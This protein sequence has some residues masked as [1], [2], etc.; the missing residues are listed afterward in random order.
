MQRLLLT[1]SFLNQTL[2]GFF[3]QREKQLLPLHPTLPLLFLLAFVVIILQ[4]LYWC[5]FFFLKEGFPVLHTIWATR[6]Y[7]QY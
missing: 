7:G 3:R 2:V 6:P 4:V 1:S 5:E